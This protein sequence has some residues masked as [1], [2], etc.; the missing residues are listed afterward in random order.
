VLIEN[1]FCLEIYKGIVL[2]TQEE[3]AI[4][5]ERVKSR[6][7]QLYYESR[8]YQLLQGGDGLTSSFFFLTALY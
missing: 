1:I 3:V 8:I 2:N 6:Q 7:L 5:L 4:K